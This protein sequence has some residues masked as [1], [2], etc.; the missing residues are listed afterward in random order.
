MGQ[1]KWHHLRNIKCFTLHNVHEHVD[2]E[3]IDLYSHT[4]SV[5]EAV[6]VHMNA[7]TAGGV[8]ENIFT[9]SVSQAE[10]IPHH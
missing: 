7:V 4:Y 6:E 3:S 1:S 10:D 9:M 2:N 5:E 8:K